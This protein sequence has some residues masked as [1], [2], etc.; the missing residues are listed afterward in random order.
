MNWRRIL[1]I[2]IVF[3]IFH[4]LSS[5]VY[6]AK[7]IGHV[8]HETCTE[9]IGHVFHETCTGASERTVLAGL[10]V[11]VVFT[12]VNGSDPEWLRE[13]KKYNENSE[14]QEFHLRF[15]DEKASELEFAVALVRK[16]APWVRR[17][18]VVVANLGIPQ[19]PPFYLK[20]PQKLQITLVSH[21]M[22]FPEDAL[23]T[24]NSHAIEAN[25]HRIP[26]LAE[27]FLYFNDD[28]FLMKP[29]TKR[30]CFGLTAAPKQIVPI[31]QNMNRWML[32][33]PP[34]LGGSVYSRVWYRM[35]TSP[36]IGPVNVPWHGFHA[37][38]KCS[39]VD[40][41][42]S[43]YTS[44]QATVSSR[45][46][47]ETDISPIGLCVNAALKKRKMFLASPG[48]SLH[49][50]FFNHPGKVVTSDVDVETDV[51]CL[52]ATADVEVSIKNL[53]LALGVRR[54]LQQ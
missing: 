25:L 50:S 12:W 53:V 4:V 7:R 43:F 24:F 19:T 2:L 51:F 18:F 46:R 42:N 38:S 27:F 32:H 28:V 8:F 17:I 36:E 5:R 29:L 16:N 6:F 44:W 33:F 47:S 1:V 11:D 49:L 41:E 37:L 40:A 31:V 21:A 26:G 20:S 48:R 23:P 52:N 30:K 39:M 10:D 54:G 13:Y 14:S 15:G 34:Q 22:I 45:F 35:A 3:L 9:R